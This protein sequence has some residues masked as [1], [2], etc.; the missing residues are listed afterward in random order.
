MNAQIIIDY[1]FKLI[2][3]VKL[4]IKS[5]ERWNAGSCVAVS[6]QNFYNIWTT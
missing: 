3:T 6:H 5:W 1:V 2:F 4:K